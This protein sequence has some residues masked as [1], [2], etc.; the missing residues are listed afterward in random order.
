MSMPGPEQIAYMQAHASDDLRS[1]VIACCSVCAFFAA[2]FVAA[3]LFARHLSSKFLLADW[4][5]I[6]SFVSCGPGSPFTPRRPLGDAHELHEGDD[7]DGQL[8]LN[9]VS[10]FHFVFASRC[11]LSMGS[12]GTSSSRRTRAGCR[13]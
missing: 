8:N 11:A 7:A 12:E 13:L 2:V 3:R 5:N 10:I 6:F 9:S 4:L 1:N